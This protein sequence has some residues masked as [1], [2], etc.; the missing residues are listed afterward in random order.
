MA[1]IAASV[2][3][4]RVPVTEILNAN[5]FKEDVAEP[6]MAS[7]MQDW[8]DDIETFNTT[9]QRQVD[10]ADIG[11]VWVATLAGNF[12]TFHTSY[13]LRQTGVMETYA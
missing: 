5:I 13:C 3:T 2:E 12:I 10:V 7:A 11:N 8:F 4:Q 6:L 1:A 9:A